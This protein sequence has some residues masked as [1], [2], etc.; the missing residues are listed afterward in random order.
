MA[1]EENILFTSSFKAPGW[2]ADTVTLRSD[3]LDHIPVP[4]SGPIVL[5]EGF[6]NPVFW[7]CLSA[8]CT[9]DGSAAVAPAW[10]ENLC[11]CPAPLPLPQ[12]EPR[13][14]PIRL[15][16]WYSVAQWL[17][18]ENQDSHLT[19]SKGSKKKNYYRLLSTYYLPGPIHGPLHSIHPH[20]SPMR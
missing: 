18:K 8:G 6:G 20:K 13:R 1:S 4:C 3:V 16:Q 17:Q 19:L 14:Q 9:V 2:G 12:G 10:G 11:P 7:C 5:M 15:L